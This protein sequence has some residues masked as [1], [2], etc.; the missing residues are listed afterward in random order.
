MD[1]TKPNEFIGFG[2]MDVTKPYE[3]IGFGAMRA[4]APHCTLYKSRHD[5]APDHTGARHIPDPRSTAA[6]HRRTD[7]TSSPS[8]G[9]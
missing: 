1:V 5:M 9:E 2:A 4:T 8:F 6:A 3:F 7:P